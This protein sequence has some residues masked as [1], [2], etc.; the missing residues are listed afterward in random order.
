MAK[1]TISREELDRL[2][3]T[4]EGSLKKI[5]KTKYQGDPFGD[6]QISITDLINVARD[7]I[8][9]LKSLTRSEHT[10]SMLVDR[11]ERQAIARKIET[12]IK[13]ISDD[14][15]DLFFNNISETIRLLRGMNL[16]SGWSLV[17]GAKESAY[18][19]QKK[20][21]SLEKR[22]QNLALTLAKLERKAAEI[23]Q[24]RA[25]IN[26][27]AETIGKFV[28]NIDV[29]TVELNTQAESTKNFEQKLIQFEQSQDELIEKAENLIH[30]A[31][32]ALEVRTAEGL[33][34]AFK[35]KADSSKG[36]K[37]LWWIALAVL[38]MGATFY[39][40]YQLIKSPDIGIAHVLARLSL[41]PILIAGAWFSAARYV[42]QK[43]L[44]EDYDYKQVLMSSHVAFSRQLKEDT[45]NDE[46]Y[47]E[48]LKGFLREIYQHPVKSR[49]NDGSGATKISSEKISEDKSSS[50]RLL[51][52]LKDLETDIEQSLT[53]GR[54]M[55]Q[56]LGDLNSKW[57][58]VQE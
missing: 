25:Q 49:C 13:N 57:D 14:R 58:S 27:Q 52:K 4:L 47:Q 30:Q 3:T 24:L 10:F 21:E 39:I 40:G 29:R 42:F 38:F 17:A 55:E 43:N 44:A 32:T 54:R 50:E 36:K 7:L 1:Q 5:S 23:E 8:L 2:L 12:L 48:Y 35:T 45:G 53:R 15:I 9:S 46:S 22:E 28:A 31:E 6:D 16:R 11:D 41:I 56:Q 34:T 33:S 19:L 37:Y 26:K 20:A 18:E 51:S